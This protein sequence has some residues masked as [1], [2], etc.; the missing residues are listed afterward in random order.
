MTSSLFHRSCTVETISAQRMRRLAKKEP[1]YLAMVGTTNEDAA[2]TGNES[3]NK[4]TVSINEDKT[5][6]VYPIQ[7]QAILNDFTYVFPK[8]LP[9]GLPP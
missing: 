7:M 3:R 9:V 4:S 2:N 8:D 1:I 6:T 5:Q